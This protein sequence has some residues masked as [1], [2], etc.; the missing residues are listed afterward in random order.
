MLI[1][2]VFGY[3]GALCI[4]LTLGLTGAGGSILTVPI[5]VYLLGFDS[6]LSTAYS[7]FIVGATA[8][9]G[10]IRNLIKG[11]TKV[12]IALWFGLPSMLSIFLTRK[13]I[14]TNLPDNLLAIQDFVLTKQVGVLLLFATLMI[15]SGLRMVKAKK[16]VTIEVGSEGN[17]NFIKL[18]LQGLFV[19]ILTGLVGAG[20]GFLIVPALVL[21]AKLP[22]KNAVGTSLLIIASN[23]LIGFSGDISHRVI[24]WAFLLPFASIAVIGI[25]LGMLLADKVN[26]AQLKKGFGYFV[27]TVAAFIVS[28]EVWTLFFA[29]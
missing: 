7:L 29:A 14:V 8:S 26:G 15:F 25:F 12:K 11:F 28:K 13:Y 23:S 18:A 5:L 19:G 24:D 10:A 22:M 17:V 4:G 27:L 6:L 20:G 16:K 3:I 21:M 1:S 9:V 2:E